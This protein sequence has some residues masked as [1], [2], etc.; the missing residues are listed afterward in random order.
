[1]LQ[2]RLVSTNRPELDS[3]H[4]NLHVGFFYGKKINISNSKS[5]H[6][7]IKP[8]VLFQLDANQDLL[9][10]NASSAQCPAHRTHV[11][12]TDTA[13]V[14]PVPLFPAMLHPTTMATFAA[15]NLVSQANTAKRISTIV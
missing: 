15:A 7:L 13:T 10:A 6:S 1:M 14:F 3:Q 12:Q 9:V 11:A 4:E 2:R 8:T 5:K